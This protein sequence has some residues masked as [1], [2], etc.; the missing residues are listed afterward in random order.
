[1]LSGAAAANGTESDL[2][3]NASGICEDN[4]S[5][6]MQA[7]AGKE[8]PRQCESQPARFSIVPSSVRWH[9]KL[10]KLRV[11]AENSLSW[12]EVSTS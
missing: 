11:G 12:S 9:H 1:M 3:G 2:D 4:A 5:I 10:Q 6:S 8:D 7:D